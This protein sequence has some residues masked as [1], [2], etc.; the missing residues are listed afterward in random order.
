M[1]RVDE[2]SRSSPNRPAVNGCCVEKSSASSAQRSTC[3]SSSAPAAASSANSCTGP[4]SSLVGGSSPST[5]VCI[6]SAISSS[7]T[8]RMTMQQPPDVVEIIGHFKLSGSIGGQKQAQCD[9][10]P[11]AAARRDNS[12]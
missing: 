1:G 6:F 9:F 12:H 5:W 11:Y 4:S 7:L 10:R 2:Q 3:S 8:K